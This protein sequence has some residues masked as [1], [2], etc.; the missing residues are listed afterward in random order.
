[1]RVMINTLFPASLITN[2]NGQDSMLGLKVLLVK[3]MLE[4]ILVSAN[5]TECAFKIATEELA[6]LT[7]SLRTRIKTLISRLETT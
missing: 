2:M 1:M 5:L 6:E 4:G 7:N 3:D